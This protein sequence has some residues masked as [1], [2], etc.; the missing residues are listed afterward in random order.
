MPSLS[1]QCFA[2]GM[3]DL[4]LTIVKLLDTAIV[5]GQRTG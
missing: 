3:N 5:S 2:P 1:N 4:W